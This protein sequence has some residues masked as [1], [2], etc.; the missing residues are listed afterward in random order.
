MMTTMPPHQYLQG[1]RVAAY[2]I[3]RFVGGP[4]HCYP[5]PGFLVGVPEVLVRCEHEGQPIEATYSLGICEDTEGISR[6]FYGYEGMVEDEIER[7]LTMVLLP[8]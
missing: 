5:V 8:C 6:T 4:M 2:D 1:R 7:L 3:V